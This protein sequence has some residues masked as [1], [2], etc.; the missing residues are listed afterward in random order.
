MAKKFVRGI[1]NIKTINNQDFDTN[2]VNDLLSDGTHN[3]IHR[4]KADKSEEY[5]C[6]T[7]NIKKI[8]NGDVGLMDVAED[9]D[10]NAVTITVKHDASKQGKLTPGYGMKID[11][12][13]IITGNVP[14]S[15]REQYELNNF[16]EGII[17]GFNLKN[18]PD[19]NWWVIF[20]YSEG[21]YTIQQA[22]K[23]VTT[24]KYIETRIRYKQ[25]TTWTEWLDTAPDSVSKVILTSPN[26]TTYNLTVSDSGTVSATPVSAT[27]A[28]IPLDD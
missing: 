15:V 10:N 19:T 12:N 27:A 11:N 21:N 16:S 13:N 18:A 26:G 1:T 24:G 17:K 20:A 14:T 2:S 28:T 4:R 8:K 5:H 22:M 6:L 25:N 9:T 23:F 7:D 3:Y